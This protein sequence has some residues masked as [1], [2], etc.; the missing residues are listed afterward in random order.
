MLQDHI[1]DKHCNHGNRSNNALEAYFTSYSSTLVQEQLV[2]DHMVYNQ[3]VL[4][5]K[6]IKA[7][8]F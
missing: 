4:K 7:K 5:D 2:K 1:W 6:L 3:L 8:I